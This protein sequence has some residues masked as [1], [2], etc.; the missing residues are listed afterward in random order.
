MTQ[1]PISKQLTD[2][3]ELFKSG[4]L[5]KEEY[6]LLKS[7]IINGGETQQE[8]DVQSKAES[9]GI[10]ANTENKT[11][12][13]KPKQDKT[14]K[15]PV[16]KNAWISIT[17]LLL[18]IVAT[19][20]FVFNENGEWDKAKATKKILKE[21]DRSPEW[22]SKTGEN[23]TIWHHHIAGFKNLDL[24]ERKVNVAV[25]VTNK[26]EDEV[27]FGS[28]SIFEFDESEKWNI[29]NSSI[30]FTENEGF[31]LSTQLNNI[32]KI[33]SNNY[34]FIVKSEDNAMGGRSM[35]SIQLFSFLAGEFKIVFND[36]RGWQSPDEEPV[37]K[38]HMMENAINLSEEVDEYYPIE[39]IDNSD[40]RFHFDV[41][42]YYSFN[43]SEYVRKGY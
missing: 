11:I 31:I 29:S 27:G 3:F 2:L 28:F 22:S 7:E 16:K 14:K 18:A 37:F 25:V 15:N 36:S 20:L 21:L 32:H 38:L 8:K 24:K 19:Y 12:N 10:N 41:S 13:Q 30:A 39:A 35:I 17:V 1:E 4:A 9:L 42:T 6:E 33:S 40:R 34:G 5:S 43:G 26:Y 23:P